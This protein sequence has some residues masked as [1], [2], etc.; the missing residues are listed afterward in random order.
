MMNWARLVGPLRVS[1]LVG[2]VVTMVWMMF[3]GGPVESGVFGP[4][5]RPLN[6]FLFLFGILPYLLLLDMYWMIVV[7]S[8][9]PFPADSVQTSP[10][11]RARAFAEYDLAALTVWGLLGG[12]REFANGLELEIGNSLPLVAG[13]ANAIVAYCL[14][15]AETVGMRIAV[16]LAAA[17][18]AALLLWLLPQQVRWV[19]VLANL[20]A[21]LVFLRQRLGA[22]RVV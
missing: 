6:L 17:T 11:E 22:R 1:M 20:A 19:F 2:F 7:G 18:T 8:P 14:L 16:S 13:L 15:R 9:E 21:M 4:G 12:A 10:R 5:L 3:G